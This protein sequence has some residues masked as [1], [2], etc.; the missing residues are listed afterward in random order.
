MLQTI[1]NEMSFSIK[2]GTILLSL[3]I[4]G[5]L[6]AVFV[7]FFKNE[8]KEK[9]ET[10]VTRGFITREQDS[11]FEKKSISIQPGNSKIF[12]N[13]EF[14]NVIKSGCQIMKDENFNIS[15]G[16]DTIGF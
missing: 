16:D 10:V 6:I 13:K 14:D 11:V 8:K 7:A 4:L 2:L 15:E 1:L 3:I 5:V 12:Q 9:I